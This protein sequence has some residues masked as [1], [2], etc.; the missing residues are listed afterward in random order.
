VAGGRTQ[1]TDGAARSRARRRARVAVSLGALL[2]LAAVVVPAPA[3]AG[4]TTPMA[5]IPTSVPELVKQIMDA[6]FGTGEDGGKGLISFTW[7]GWLVTVPNYPAQGGNVAALERV[8]SAIGL[9]V[10]GAAV[11]LSVFNHWAGGFAGGGGD[12]MQGVFRSVGAALFIIAWPWI[13]MSGAALANQASMTVLSS[14]AQQAIATA[15][16]NPVSNAASET[17]GALVGFLLLP[18]IALAATFGA[19]GLTITKTGVDAGLVLGYVAVPITVALSPVPGF[20]WLSKF[21]LRATTAAALVPFVWALLLAATAAIGIDA[22]THSA[23][24][25]GDPMASLV[26]PL[27]TVG[28][29]VLSLKVPGMLMRTAGVVPPG[30]GFLKSTASFFAARLAFGAVS[31]HVPNALGGTRDSIARQRALDGQRETDRA[32]RLERDSARDTRAGGADE[33]RPQAPTEATGPSQGGTPADPSA[34]QS[35]TTPRTAHGPDGLPTQPDPERY[36]TAVARANGYQEGGVYGADDV[37]GAL[38]VLHARGHEYFSETR[39]RLTQWGGPGL[40]DS[41][42]ARLADAG[43][44]DGLPSDVRDAFR[45]AAGTDPATRHAAASLWEPQGQSKT[46]SSEQ[47]APA[48]EPTSQPSSSSPTGEES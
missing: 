27:T 31:S 26:A 38:D 8:T 35:K 46:L 3:Y 13:F 2:V 12:V 28:V 23:A 39:G 24:L 18:L 32:Q 20:D 6:L 47:A 29:L 17:L 37:T 11:T 22:M 16:S 34:G 40:N 5:D 48:A 30:S 41:T 15:L 10:L 42:T 1:V 45:T 7:L 21:S 43:E 44:A 36:R 9:A 19:I 4:A 25:Q 33:R 14:S